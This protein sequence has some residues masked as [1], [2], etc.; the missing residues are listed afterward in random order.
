MVKQIAPLSNS[1]HYFLSI[2]FKISCVHQ[3]V[4]IK[5]YVY[6]IVIQILRSDEISNQ[7][8]V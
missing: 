8:M 7:Q 4:I 6:V 3:H 1:E 5:S 2:K